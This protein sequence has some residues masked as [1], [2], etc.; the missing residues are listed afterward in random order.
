MGKSSITL[1]FTSNTFSEKYGVARARSST[2]APIDPTVDDSY[3][4]VLTLDGEDYTLE[5]LDTAGTVRRAA[6]PAV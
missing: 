3:T 2:H 5:I 1:R 4:K 6:P